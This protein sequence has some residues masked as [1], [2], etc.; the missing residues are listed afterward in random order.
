MTKLLY[1]LYE[2]LIL[3][4]HFFCGGYIL[5]K[6]WEWCVVS[7]FENAIHINHIFAVQILVG[8]KFLSSWLEVLTISEQLNLSVKFV[9]GLIFYSISM[10]AIWAIAM[11]NGM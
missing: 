1:K 6:F 9:F 11:S 5:S 3:T 2:I 10:L 8:I 4:L 7:R